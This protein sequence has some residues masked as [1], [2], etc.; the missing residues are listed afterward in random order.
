MPDAIDSEMLYILEAGE[1]FVRRIGPGEI[2]EALMKASRDGKKVTLRGQGTAEDNILIVDLVEESTEAQEDTPPLTRRVRIDLSSTPQLQIQILETPLSNLSGGLALATL[3]EPERS[4][5]GPLAAGLVVGLLIVLG[6]LA[7]DIVTDRIILGGMK[8]LLLLM[9]L[10]LLILAGNGLLRQIKQG[11][12]HKQK[13]ENG[14]GQKQDDGQDKQDDEGEPTDEG[15]GGTETGIALHLKRVSF[16]GTGFRPVVRDDDPEASYDAPHWEDNSNP[17][18]G[19]ARD[20]GDRRFPVCYL[21]DHTPTIAAEWVIDQPLP[22]FQNPMVRGSGLGDINVPESRVTIQ[23]GLMILDPVEA[24]APFPN[25]ITLFVPFTIAWEFSPD[26]GE[27]WSPAG[28]SENRVYVTLD[29]RRPDSVYFE[30]VLHIS[31]QNGQDA[32]NSERAFEQIW[33]GFSPAKGDGLD[34][35]SV[36]GFNHEDGEKMTYWDPQPTGNTNRQNATRLREMLS[37]REEVHATCAA[38]A[39]LLHHA[40]GVQGIEA[41]LVKVET[42]YQ[43]DDGQRLEGD[44]GGM[45]RGAILIKEWTFNERGTLDPRCQPFTHDW[46]QEVAYSR[47]TQSQGNANPPGKFLEHYVVYYDRELYDPSYGRGPFGT[48]RAG[49]AFGHMAS[50]WENESVAGFVKRCVV[51]GDSFL[52]SKEN[53]PDSQEIKYVAFA[54]AS[55]FR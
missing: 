47:P 37:I 49:P 23:N 40:L 6:L 50:N 19:N 38:W 27:T 32:T 52:A 30:T 12:S 5:R 31:C 7:S 4:F 46:P 2:F 26:G 18:N 55:A 36:D 29:A 35:K 21:R 44:I 41:Y 8:G 54:N 45:N 3:P 15:Q 14:N 51:I 1:V 20:I 25:R 24:T 28:Q 43:N 16:S 11:R 42:I 39:V 48:Q 33:Q 17:L 22:V 10:V 9:A 13:D 34:R 53:D